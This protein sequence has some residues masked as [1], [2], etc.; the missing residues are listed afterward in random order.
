MLFAEPQ[1]V[2]PLGEELVAMRGAF[3]SQ[4]IYGSFGRYA[5]SQLDRL[6][7]NQRLAEHRTTIIGWRLR[8][9]RGEIPTK[10]SSWFAAR[11][12][13]SGMQPCPV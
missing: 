8:A 2:D 9:A 6:E 1:V 11:H 7:H 12:G 3:L 4:E 5:L 13:L 10:V